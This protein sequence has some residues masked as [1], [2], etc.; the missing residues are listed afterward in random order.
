MVA[1][2]FFEQVNACL[3]GPLSSPVSRNQGFSNLS[4]QTDIRLDVAVE[5]QR[6]Q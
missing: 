1:P 3:R 4:A 5:P 6:T 2:D